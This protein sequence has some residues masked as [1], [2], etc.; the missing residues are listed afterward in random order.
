MSDPGRQERSG[1]WALGNMGMQFGDCESR[2]VLFFGFFF[3][4]LHME[5]RKR[6][7]ALASGPCGDLDR[8][9][10]QQVL[11][12]V[13]SGRPRNGVFSGSLA[14]GGFSAAE[15]PVYSTQAVAASL[16]IF[17]GLLWALP[18]T[19]RL[20]SAAPARSPSAS[21]CSLPPYRFLLCIPLPLA[22][23]SFWVPQLKKKKKEQKTKTQE[24]DFGPAH[25]CLDGV[26]LPVDITDH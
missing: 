26:V 23:S 3:M 11:L 19:G 22:S 1:T 25:P 4:R 21:P 9:H 2:G 12:E 16:P 5:S 15:L 20:R 6:D 14:V 8:I 24:Q 17:V 7:S 13:G 18:P 10:S